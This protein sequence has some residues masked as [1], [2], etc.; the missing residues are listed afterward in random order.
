[1][2]ASLTPTVTNWM[3]RY[4]VTAKSQDGPEKERIFSLPALV[5]AVGLALVVLSFLPFDDLVTSRL[6]TAANAAHYNK[7]TLEY[8]QSAYQTP[9][10]AGLTQSQWQARHKRLQE[11]VD[12]LQNKLA[13]AQRR[14]RTWSRIL[15][16]SGALL[17][18]V[19]GLRY[20]SARS[21]P[22]IS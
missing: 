14:P 15:L 2:M 20:Q 6:W 17:T 12:S 16:W 1:M 7:I 13:S 9:G 8:H 18:L 21:S 3:G 10:R 11:E 22:N 4:H 5:V 19:G